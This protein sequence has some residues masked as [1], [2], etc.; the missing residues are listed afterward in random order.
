MIDLV[1]IALAASGAGAVAVGA[2][3]A[4]ERL[5]GR[6]GGVLA[7]VPTTIVPATAS[8]WS[9][10]SGGASPSDAYA[11]AM[12]LVPIGMLM[13]TAVL[14]TW[15]EL[16]QRLP[17]GWTDMRR[18]WVTL[19][20][21]LVVWLAGSS[22]AV[23]A[24]QALDPTPLAAAVAGAIAWILMGAVGV[25]MWRGSHDAP[26]GTRRVPVPTLVMRGAAA[27]VAIA[28]ASAIAQS[29]WTVASGVASTFPAIFVTTMVATWIAQGSAVPL[30]ATAPM[31]LGSLSVGAYAA[32][33]AFAYPRLG[34]WAGVPLC[35][36]GAVLAT[37]LPAH[38]W[39]SRSAVAAR[40]SRAQ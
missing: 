40:P 31:V 20:T 35:W 32:L 26:R 10:H 15:R 38:L 4:I 5:G 27:A 14:V 36:I 3:L 1:H 30:G 34:L 33:S 24:E 25:L 28:G 23:A 6:A 12:A 29:G 37:S 19:W 13:C 21:S 22:A 2:T 18:M 8:I 9:S 7:T 17:A 16:P 11:I 39:L